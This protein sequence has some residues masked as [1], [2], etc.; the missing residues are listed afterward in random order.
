MKDF[1][2][3]ANIVG[4]PYNASDSLFLEGVRPLLE[5]RDQL[6]WSVDCNLRLVVMNQGFQA[7]VE[8]ATGKKPRRGMSYADVFREV[9]AS[10][11]NLHSRR[12][13]KGERFSLD[14][15]FVLGDDTVYF[16]VFF[17]PQ[18]LEG[19]TTGVTMWAVDVT[20]IRK[21]S[22]LTERIARDLG[23]RVKE[24]Q[25]LHEVSRLLQTREKSTG[26]VL[27]VLVNRIPKAFLHADVAEARIVFGGE[28]WVTPGFAEGR[29]S[30]KKEFVTSDGTRGCVE[31]IYRELCPDQQIGPFLDEEVD[32]IGSVAEMV[33]SF[34]DRRNAELE[35]VRT[36]E[37]FR[38]IFEASRDG[39]VV[40]H[41]EKIVFANTAA[42]KLY[43]YAGPEELIGNHVSLLQ[44][45]GDNGRLLEFG[46]LRR[47]GKP[48]PVLYEFKG[49][50]KDGTSIDLEASVSTSVIDGKMYIIAL[51]RDVRERKAAERA[52][53]DSEEQYRRFFEDDLSGNFIS[54]PNGRLIACNPVFLRIFGFSSL[55][56]ALDTDLR[57]LYRE[58][59]ER[60][61]YLKRLTK[62]KRLEEV[63][64]RMR[65]K[66]GKEIETVSNIAGE[67]DENGKLLVIKGSIL[68]VTAQ[69]EAR[70]RLE[71]QAAILDITRDAIMVRRFDNTITLWNKAAE[72][73]Y[74]WSDVVGR[75]ITELFPE[76][77]PVFQEALREV[78]EKEE[79]NGEYERAG[80]TGKTLI[81]E[82][83]WTLIRGKDGEPD[84][85]LVV[86]TDVTG[87][88][89][90]QKQVV[91]AQRL[92]SL[93]TL[94]GGIAHDLNNV[95]GPVLMGTEIL[96]KHTQDASLLKLLESMHNSVQRGAEM[97][98]QVLAF[99]RGMEGKRL[100][101]QVK[102]IVQEIVTFVSET[103]PK[104]IEIRRDIQ[105]DVPPV[106]GDPTQ[107]HQVILNLAV[108][109][110]DA[111][112]EGGTLTIRLEKTEV[113][114]HY[115]T[116]NPGVSPG[117]YVVLSVKDTGVGI[118]PNVL[119]HIFEPFFTTKPQGQGTGLGLST[120]MGIVRSHGGYID[121]DSQQG[122]GSEFR[123]YL[124]ASSGS[125]ETGS[126]EDGHPEG[127]EGET[128][129]LVEDEVSILDAS[130][131]ILEAG[132]YEVLTAK[133]GTEALAAYAR[134][135]DRIRLIVTDMSMPLMNGEA[136]I[137]AV[138]YL[139]PDLPVIVSS[140]LPF[141]RDGLGS[142]VKAI[143]QKP[144]TGKQ[145]LAMVRTV[146]AEPKITT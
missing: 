26:E 50:C 106:L 13:L 62:E 109:A 97:V 112:P 10:F 77:S 22:A 118:A 38:A 125:E 85:I 59:G 61:E 131:M 128:I 82:S 86:E 53:E 19:V 65:R 137:R 95:L 81:L 71:E 88:R 105:K 54:T 96:K 84:S 60:E 83:R 44:S 87:Q 144:Y 114:E 116:M 23:E 80:K 111:M 17:A 110:R 46:R 117:T 130:K 101:V 34:L 30:L 37:W 63:A 25:L 52:L 76:N 56:E 143:L 31:V 40:E 28:C 32:L 133:D 1:V 9:E 21:Q 5:T 36:N 138:R 27:D 107:I 69:K 126:K 58:E 100:T 29:E 141:D 93:G 129:L 73:L 134:H 47:E 68:D 35:L 102:H 78:L 39:I 41:E 92:E 42:A 113:D 70:R 67:F 94:A 14:V 136:T 16:K 135:K 122:M 104:S 99:A 4:H 7:V 79:W 11:W 142:T 139:N 51:E 108:N 48:A 33:R 49:K 72:R 45:E 98:K 115:R 121:V 119:E 15:P 6:I 8:R 123:V 43:G 146:L 12:G 57:T 24:L 18:K 64:R 74:G 20:E 91:R 89:A 66:D 103:F 90:F 120:A 2:K 3:R 132:G 124:P 75:K 140:G 127:G 145:L 55:E